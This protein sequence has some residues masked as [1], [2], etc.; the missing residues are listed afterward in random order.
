DGD[1]ER[2][3]PGNAG[4]D[5]G[6]GRQQFGQSG[7]EQDVVESQ[8]LAQGS[9]GFLLHCQLQWS[10]LRACSTAPSA[11]RDAPRLR[12]T[13]ARARDVTARFGLA[14]ADSTARARILAI[15]RQFTERTRVVAAIASSHRPP[16]A[17]I[18]GANPAAAHAVRSRSPTRG[19]CDPRA[20]CGPQ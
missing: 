16:W 14:L 1:I 5:V 6:V 4:A 18:T 11:D 12:R 3:V 9:V 10:A 8:C 19:A 7:L 2:D 15:L 17:R 20:S 13:G